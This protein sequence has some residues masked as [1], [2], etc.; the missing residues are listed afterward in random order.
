[1]ICAVYKYIHSFIMSHTRNN[2]ASNYKSLYGTFYKISIEVVKAKICNLKKMSLTSGRS[3]C[4]WKVVPK[5]R[6][7]YS[8][9]VIGKRA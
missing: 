9:A 8:V 5:C 6:C 1:M 3:N 7:G 4:I 2:M